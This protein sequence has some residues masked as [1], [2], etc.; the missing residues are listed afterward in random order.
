MEFYSDSY[1][2]EK[3]HGV[4]GK[5]RKH[6]DQGVERT[7]RR[8]DE[9]KTPTP[10]SIG[11]LIVGLFIGSLFFAC[12]ASTPATVQQN[13]AYAIAV[14]LALAGLVVVTAGLLDKWR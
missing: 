6:P 10:L 12:M 3:G 11:W 1:L 5:D 4:D 13:I 7:D 14:L 9:M 2:T 8:M